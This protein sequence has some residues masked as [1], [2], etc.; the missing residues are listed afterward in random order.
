M[1]GGSWGIDGDDG[2]SVEQRLSRL[3]YYRLAGTIKNRNS[4]KIRDAPGD[5]VIS[6]GYAKCEMVA[7]AERLN[8]R[9]QEERVGED[10]GGGK[11]TT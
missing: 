11:R 8:K 9:I 4:K 2:E 3:R 1:D 7:R 6:G 10:D 5:D